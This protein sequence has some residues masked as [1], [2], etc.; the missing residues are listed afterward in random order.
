MIAALAA[1]TPLL[2]FA[3]APA[4]RP[5]PDTQPAPATQ[6]AATQPSPEVLGLIDQMGTGSFQT[7]MR[8]QLALVKM[9]APVEP[10]LKQAS[11]DSP[12][13]EIRDRAAMAVA[14]IEQNIAAAPTFITLHVKDALGQDVLDQIS[15]QAKVRVLG[16]PDYQWK[17]HRGPA[18]PPIT[19]DLDHVPFWV[20]IEAVCKITRT[21]PQYMGP[22]TRDISLVQGGGSGEWYQA[23]R[24]AFVPMAMNHDSQIDLVGGGANKN[25]AMTMEVFLD[26]KIHSID[27]DPPKIDIAKDDQGHSLAP[28]ANGMMNYFYRPGFQQQWAIDLQAP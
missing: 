15:R 1:L 7:R 19:L 3:D 2:A 9:G 16:W 27:F 22:D 20:A 28:P 14:E 12:N 13:P 18:V 11:S 10:A 24:F 21:H 25:D 23:G 4:T 5:A 26:P 17:N 8:A 6:P